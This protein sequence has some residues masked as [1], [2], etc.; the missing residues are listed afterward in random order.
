MAA[1]VELDFDFNTRKAQ[2]DLKKIDRGVK[3]ID[4]SAK[5]ITKS[6]GRLSK[7]RFPQ[8]AGIV[9]AAAAIRGI[10]EATDNFANYQKEGR[11]TNIVLQTTNDE[12]DKMLSKSA[13]L[14]AE[15]GFKP[16]FIQEAKTLLAGAGFDIPGIERGA[17]VAA[18]LAVAGDQLPAAVTPALTSVVAAFG[19]TLKEAGDTITVVFNKSKATFDQ[20]GKAFEV[21][22]G[23]FAAQG[24]TKGQFGAITA[25]LSL[26]GL[27]G[28]ELGTFGKS[29][30]TALFKGTTIEGVGGLGKKGKFGVD[31]QLDFGAL[32]VEKRIEVLKRIQKQSDLAFQKLIPDTQAQ[33]AL[34]G[35]F[36][37]GLTKDKDLDPLFRA[38]D[39][40]SDALKKAFDI[41]TSDSV[42]FDLARARVQREVGFLALGRELAPQVADLSVKTGELVEN[43]KE[44]IR[45][46][47]K[48]GGFVLD[49]VNATLSPIEI[50][51]GFAENAAAT[52]Q[53]TLTPAGRSSLG[54]TAVNLLN[55]PSNET[56][57]TPAETNI[58]REAAQV[59]TPESISVQTQIREVARRL[60]TD[61]TNK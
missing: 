4:K 29:L 60:A 46:I 59:F 21:G 41:K 53:Q 56:G 30:S 38:F 20:L 57:L 51:K 9:S 49:F 17:R 15:F 54:Q 23:A 11:N 31:E 27:P 47:G 1:D 33:L 10:S 2:S 61:P 19:G 43:N 40:T 35:L 42:S 55:P 6:F 24:V 37:P 58:E 45:E 52:F 12:I 39:D 25:K 28:G 48:F 13:R 18:Q 34:R 44:L 8:L 32:D 26:A 22:G 50:I 3:K 16:V 5:G 14:G 7:I 36:K